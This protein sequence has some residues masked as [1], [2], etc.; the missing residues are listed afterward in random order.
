[1]HLPIKGEL[2]S[3]VFFWP[4]IIGYHRRC[5]I[6][7]KYALLTFLKSGN[8]EIKVQVNLGW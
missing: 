3:G 8:P 6:S 2:K 4:P 5:G 1:M 7:K